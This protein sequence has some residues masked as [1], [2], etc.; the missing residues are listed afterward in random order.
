MP[1]AGFPLADGFEAALDA[2]IGLP[3]AADRID[4]LT[5]LIRHA[6]AHGDRDQRRASRATLVTES[7]DAG[8]LGRQAIA[9]PAFAWLLADHDRDPDAAEAGYVTPRELLGWYE[10][11]VRIAGSD[12]AIPRRK[13]EA[14]VADHDRRT[15]AWGGHESGAAGS[16]FRAAEKL[17]DLEAL[18]ALFGRELRALRSEGQDYPYGTAGLVGLFT[19]QAD[20]ALAA[21]R[22]I[23]DGT[24]PLAWLWAANRANFRIWML[25]PLVWAGLHAE[26]DRRYRRVIAAGFQ[27]VD[28]SGFV[29]EYAARVRDERTLR[30]WLPGVLRACGSVTGDGAL[31]LVHAALACE[32]L[33]ELG[34]APLALPLPTD[35]PNAPPADADGRTRPSAAAGPL[36]AAAAA[37]AARL[38][39]RNGNDTFTRGLIGDRAFVFGPEEDVRRL[40]ADRRARLRA[41]WEE[42]GT[43]PPGS[44]PDS[45]DPFY[46]EAA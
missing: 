4:A 26:A 22:P 6:D 3:A 36:W 9:L 41:V 44:R 24:A 5:D 11:I 34:D 13:I 31:E 37:F 23:V 42:H 12:P 19:G 7:L 28:E 25:R 20:L 1:E 33:A 29:L 46:G 40:P 32:A 17:G 15:R 38:D 16:A 21:L 45:R 39:A 30:R 2:A 18:P 35:L 10:S 43:P 8:L 14:L 27:G